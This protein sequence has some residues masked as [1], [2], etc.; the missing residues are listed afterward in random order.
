MGWFSCSLKAKSFSEIIIINHIS[1][2]KSRQVPFLAPWARHILLIF[3]E[4]KMEETF[5]FNIASY[6]SVLFLLHMDQPHPK[7]FLNLFFGTTSIFFSFSISFWNGEK[8]CQHYSILGVKSIHSLNKIISTP[9]QLVH[10]EKRGKSNLF[11]LNFRL[12][13]K[14]LMTNKGGVGVKLERTF[15]GAVPSPED[16]AQICRKISEDTLCLHISLEHLDVGVSYPIHRGK[17]T[18]EDALNLNMLRGTHKF[19]SE[20][21]HFLRPLGGNF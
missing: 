8:K 3:T 20:V 13:W 4:V 16:R 9:F 15:L 14:V 18:G 11:C 17:T 2:I 19:T 7:Y 6:F 1:G 10:N 21:L 5:I 12:P